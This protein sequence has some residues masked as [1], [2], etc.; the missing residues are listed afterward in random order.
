MT[1]AALAEAIAGTARNPIGLATL[2][3]PYSDSEKEELRQFCNTLLGLVLV[4]RAPI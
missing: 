3:T 2:D 4:L 1:N